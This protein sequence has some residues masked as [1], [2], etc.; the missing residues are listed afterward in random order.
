MPENLVTSFLDYQDLS[1]VFSVILWLVAAIYSFGVFSEKHENQTFSL[2]GS[3]FLLQSLYDLTGLLSLNFTDYPLVF[4]TLKNVFLGLSALVL[5]NIPLAGFLGKESRK[6]MVFNAIA[7]I[8]VLLVSSLP[9]FSQVSAVNHYLIIAGI[10]FALFA[11]ITKAIQSKGISLLLVLALLS[12][13]EV[14]LVPYDGQVL[15]LVMR[16]FLAF[17][18]SFYLVGCFDNKI[19]TNTKWIRLKVAFVILLVAVVLMWLPAYWTG[20]IA[21][22]D[23]KENILLKAEAVATGL[24]VKDINDLPF[25]KESAGDKRHLQIRSQLLAFG[26][27]FPDMQGI[28]SM[29]LVDGKLYFGPESYEEND[30]LA[31]PIGT[32]YL[33]PDPRV[34]DVF[35]NGTSV[36]FGPFTDEYGTFVSAFAPVRCPIDGRVIC[37]IG[38]DVI[39]RQFRRMIYESRF[40]LNVLFIVI[41]IVGLVS[42][43]LINYRQGQ[44]AEKVPGF[45]I[46]GQIEAVST[47]CFG[48]LFSLVIFLVASNFQ[49]NASQSELSRLATL[50]FHKVK[51]SAACMQSHLNSFF[52]FG[53]K[54]EQGLSFIKD[55]ENNCQ[56]EFPSSDLFACYGVK[57]Q[58][59]KFEIVRDLCGFSYNESCKVAGIIEEGLEDSFANEGIL[60]KE[61]PEEKNNF[62]YIFKKQFEEEDKQKYFM[63]GLRIDLAR[64]IANQILCRPIEKA[65]F[66]LQ[67]YLLGNRSRQQAAFGA[68]GDKN[69]IVKED[70]VSRSRSFYFPV[71]WHDKVLLL[72]FSPLDHPN[73]LFKNRGPAIALFISS[74]MI[75]I[76]AGLM[77]RLG[78][79]KNLNLEIMVEKRTRDLARSESKFRDLVGSLSD[80]VWE[81]D[82]EGFYTFL[83]CSLANEIEIPS[84]GMINRKFYDA[85]TLVNGKEMEDFFLALIASPCNF[86]DVESVF[87]S[88]TGKRTFFA[89]SGVPFFDEDGKLLGFRGISRDITEKKASAEELEATRERYMLSVKGSQDGIW[90]WD[91]RKGQIFVSS[92]WKEMLGRESEDYQDLFD[93]YQKLLH[94]EDRGPALKTLNS[95]LQGELDEYSLEF[96]MLHKQGH[97]VWILARGEA[98][99]NSKGVA[100]RMAGSHTDISPRRE[101]EKEIER[102]LLELE[103]VIDELHTAN[104][105]AV[106]LRKAAEKANAA[107]SEFLANMSHEIRTPMNGVIGMI[108]LLLQTKLSDDQRKY[109][110]VV[111]NSGEKLLAIINDILDFSKIE[112]HK[113]ELEKVKFHPGQVV[114]EV[115]DLFVVAAKEKSIELNVDIASDLPETLVGDPNRLRQV[116]LNLVG[117]AVKFTAHGKIEVSVACKEITPGDVSLGFSVKDTGVGIPKNSRSSLFR[118]FTQG[119][120]SITRKFGGTGLGLAI[121]Q[122][123]V[124]LMGG[125]LDF[126]SEEGIGSE[127]YFNIPFEKFQEKGEETLSGNSVESDEVGQDD[128]L[129]SDVKG[130]R[131]LLVEDNQTNQIVAATMIENF[132]LSVEVADNGVDAVNMMLEQNFDI[133]FMDC[134]MPELDG[135]AATSMIRNS[136]IEKNVKV[137]IIA[138][139]ASALAGDRER[140]LASGMNDYI[141]K[142]FRIHELEIVIKRWLKSGF[143]LPEKA[144]I[145]FVQTPSEEDNLTFNY[146]EVLQRLMNNPALARTMINSFLQ[147]VPEI[148]VLLKKAIEEQNY[149]DAQT[150]AHS[151]KGAA[152]NAGAQQLSSLAKE[153]EFRF[154]NG[155]RANFKADLEAIA[156]AL[157]KFEIAVRKRQIL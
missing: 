140:C 124:E 86:F 73:N 120:G 121:S 84:T 127:F 10:I 18:S 24:S 142:P 21:E 20:K 58:S 136:G 85:P 97:Y 16:I 53:D 55:L 9:L 6:I 109:A 47:V 101:A 59:G 115:A 150:Y 157:E 63:V 68:S 8:T 64:F 133:V 144:K 87:E 138:M 14:N 122:Q 98:L 26:R 28:Y 5:I 51:D 25:V 107:K 19:F 1:L 110:D 93:V 137:P 123:L 100:Y 104:D 75:F 67:I 143:R 128:I 2:V 56:K 102:T 43:S 92:R 37:I 69:Q 106:E 62:L 30:P 77:I 103:Q 40:L 44:K 94:P 70:L 135:F 35:Q 112:A 60:L 146:S 38:I 71:F 72:R 4:V 48:F 139:T 32:L 111:K 83:H 129:S 105:S 156:E 126:S 113:L 11:A 66:N 88:K 96:R 91:I 149:K 76:A 3:F 36:S 17:V 82:P 78:R 117:N 79:Y 134:Q 54:R 15:F 89:N 130:L 155:E 41:G 95:Y 147:E 34:F 154:K 29:K 118:A 90:D 119:D 81:I 114:K 27:L 132:G 145:N 61:S 52:V 45:F 153:L 42:I 131:A 50:L 31:S 22:S 7:V 65:I 74:M 80:W 33:K 141:A 46:L 108:D 148:I 39:A 151:I 99:W 13:F 152:A 57:G 23:I 125:R 12:C 116:L 49:A